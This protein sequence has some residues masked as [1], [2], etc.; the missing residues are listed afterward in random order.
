ML[1]RLSAGAFADLCRTDV[2]EANRVH[3]IIVR[4]LAHLLG[5]ANAEK[6]ALRRIGAATT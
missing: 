5:A 1:L 2:E 6:A 3:R 4:V